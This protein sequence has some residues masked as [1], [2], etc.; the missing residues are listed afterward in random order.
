[1]D[2]PDKAQLDLA[3][4]CKSVFNTPVYPTIKVEKLHGKTILRV[5]VDEQP[6]GR[7]P[8]Y[9]KKD[10]L[11]KGAYRRIGSAD[12]VATEECLYPANT[13][14][15][16]KVMSMNL[17]SKQEDAPVIWR[18][19][20]ITGALKQ[21][22][23]D[24]CW[25]YVD[26]MFI[27]MPP[28]TGDVPLT[29][30]QSLPIDGIIVVT[31]PQDLVSMIVKKALGMAKLMKVPVLGIVENM[32][33]VKCPHCGEEIRLFGDSHV[34]EIAAKENIPVVARIPI[35]PEMT[36]YFDTGRAEYYESTFMEG[37]KDILPP[38]E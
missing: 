38:I 8:V 27:D 22:W 32:S 15:G 25:G 6:F 7:K 36:G 1:V 2:D 16:I 13:V 19:P 37:L 9:F 30:F 3:T 24:V 12:L 35:D 33:Y 14:T 18:S 5:V 21:F 20:V 10:G 26:Y 34:E 29:V 28:G 31:T 11:P 17:L 23:T 4:Q